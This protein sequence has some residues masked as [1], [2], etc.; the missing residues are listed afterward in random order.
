MRV[1]YLLHPVRPTPAEVA[2]RIRAAHAELARLAREN[3]AILARVVE[4]PTPDNVARD[5]VRENVTRAKRWLAWLQRACGR[6]RA[7]IA[8]WIDWIEV[9]GDDD[10]DPAQRARNLERCRTV[11]ERCDEAWPVGGRMSEGM[12]TEINALRAVR[13]HVDGW[14]HAELVNLVEPPAGAWRA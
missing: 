1:A 9:V 5:L 14:L 2:E 11:I 7:F 13:G 8:P 3:P 12:N 4:A 10:R 6:D